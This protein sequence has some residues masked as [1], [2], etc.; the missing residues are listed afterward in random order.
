MN[1]GHL[2]Q[3]ACLLVGLTTAWSVYSQD[4]TDRIYVNPVGF[5]FGQIKVGQL[6]QHFVTVHNESGHAATVTGGGV[7]GVFSS[8]STCGGVISSGGTCTY[9]YR[10]RPPARDR[11]S[12]SSSITI[13]ANGDT[14]SVPI[15]LDGTGVE[16]LADVYPVA[17]GF[18]E[19][20]T[21]V[22]VQIPVT[23][24]N[25][26]SS[27]L[28]SFSG[29]GVATPFSAVQNC[30]SGVSPGAS[31]QFF[32]NFSPTS[33]GVFT[34][35]SN[36]SFSASGIAQSVSV[37]L[38]GE[39]V[40]T[41]QLARVAPVEIDFGTIKRG[42]TT[43]VPLTIENVTA[44]T[45]QSFA[46]GGIGAPFS[47]AQNCGSGVP[48]GGTCQFFYSFTPD[49]ETEATTSS[50]FSFASTS[51]G[52]VAISVAL[53]GRATGTLARITPVGV[54]FGEVPT[55]AQ[56]EVPVQ[57][58]NDSASTLTSFAGGGVSNPNFSAVTTCGSPTPVGSSCA[59]TYRFSP[60]QQG[61]IEA[62]TGFNFSNGSGLGESVSLSFS[63]FGLDQLFRSGFEADE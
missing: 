24:F 32:Y 59:T 25:S 18:G 44:G 28:G 30:A 15:Q 19:Q 52:S 26:H 39:G 45:L 17:I 61:A 49:S 51:G 21:G 47:A 2:I 3:T 38:S 31:C 60:Q 27:S 1:H 40:L 36:F 20:S 7:S 37:D 5:D 16:S 54:D 22:T 46:G 56:V 8:L 43:T 63:G 10:F 41:P 6:V 29:G 50:N 23:L 62:G 55:G 11:Y 42:M 14:K 58:F 35:S 9:F 57:V 53:R 4:A 33:G 34:D 12:A 13:T 48:P